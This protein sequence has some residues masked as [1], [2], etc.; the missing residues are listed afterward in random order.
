MQERW[1]LRQK[2]IPSS[3]SVAE[4]ILQQ[5]GFTSK[6]IKNFLE[7]DPASLSSPFIFPDMK[8]A[9]TRLYKACDNQE[10]ILIFGDYDVDGITAVTLIQQFLQQILGLTPDYFVPDRVED[11]YG[12]S[13]ATLSKLD[14][15]KTD[16][17]I[18]V[19]CGIT[20][21]EETVFLQDKNIDVIITDHHEPAGSLNS[22]QLQLPPALAVINHHLLPEE[23]K[24]SGGL[25]GVGTAF[26]LCQA[27]E[28]YL[29][30]KQREVKPQPIEKEL[31]FSLSPT[32]KSNLDLVALGT[33]ADLVPLYGENRILVSQGL[34][35][36]SATENIG[37]KK[38]AAK[39]SLSLTTGLSAG[40]IG[41][42]LAPPINAAG[43]I[44]SADKAIKM[45]NTAE[46]DQAEELAADLVSLNNDRREEEE[47][48]LSEAL[49]KLEANPPEAKEA[50]ILASAD[51]HP[52]VIGIV[53]S[54]LVE[55]FYRP[56]IL[57]ALS[58]EKGRGSGR[59]IENLHLHQALKASSDYLIGF[60][61]HKQAAGLE[62]KKDNIADFKEHFN[63]Y[64]ERNLTSED[65][66]P[67]QNIDEILTAEEI[68]LSLC[69]ELESLKP[70]GIG[71]PAPVFLIPEVK[72]KKARAVGKKGRH[73]KI[74]TSQGL[75]GIGFELAKNFDF[76]TCN[77]KNEKYNILARIEKNTY[78][79]DTKTQLKIIRIVPARSKEQFPLIYQGS[80]LKL[81]DFR[82]C[83]KSLDII[84]PI[85]G[86]KNSSL[87]Y[88][89][90][91]KRK[92]ALKKQYPEVLVTT[93][94][95]EA[96][97][98]KAEAII[99]LELPFSLAEIKKIIAP[100][101]AKSTNQG[102][103]E[104]YLLFTEEDIALNKTILGHKIINKEKL[105]ATWR[106]I[107][108]HD[109][110]K[111]SKFKETLKS[112]FNLTKT[113]TNQLLEIYQEL[114]LIVV[115]PEQKNKKVKINNSHSGRLDLSTSIRYNKNVEILASFTKLQK[116]IW[117]QDLRPF[118]KIIEQ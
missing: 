90:D 53:A 102:G 2:N 30:T 79:G 70:H 39:Q 110:L 117:A 80:K 28:E 52:G 98:S 112:Q 64:L 62:I 47:R 18:T 94:I 99:L 45:L 74:E 105:L 114:D 54:R 23:N 81:W 107:S 109:Q 66:V 4:K 92:E 83:S 25:S 116:V 69:A 6:E 96:S 104:L 111:L 84:D 22:D 93:N 49:A 59:S 108:S 48:T 41:F 113:K 33:I 57:I 60:G 8:K 12:L 115:E 56:V 17:I 71:N 76:T 32:L 88:L 78:R 68:D 37:L 67:A 16:L 91:K 73:L 65:F 77:N 42:I 36:L 1:F 61:G 29:Q 13:I 27:L 40:Q 75:S 100:I 31:D 58:K 85:V 21:K 11:G 5:R 10:N 89:H 15:I 20:A 34:E 118:L 72:L 106:Q 38:L 3:D 103:K 46:V 14:L 55:K 82:N 24:I 97:Q 7:L 43:R 95:K 26:K 50:I 86:Q 19:D 44:Q 63:A 87:I 9:V 101:K 35:A 51:W